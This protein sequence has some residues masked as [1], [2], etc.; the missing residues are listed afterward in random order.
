MFGGLG[1][2]I[3]SEVSGAVRR[4]LIVY[5]LYGFAGLL[6]LCAGGY[7]LNALHSVLLFRYGAVAASLW[8][9]GGLLVAG[10]ISFGIAIS[11]KNRK[12]PS[13]PM[14]TTALMAA[15]V[16][17]KLL[18]SKMS[19]RTVLVGGVI[20]LGA[21]LGRQFFSGGGGEDEGDA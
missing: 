21:V 15:P 2:Y 14:A 7:A 20:V 8:I 12:R 18:G 6:V 19:W 11:V 3:A 9:A 1:A 17:A 5:G 10:L 16:A 4:N 13:R